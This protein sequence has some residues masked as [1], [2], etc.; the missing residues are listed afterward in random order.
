LVDWERQDFG[1][2]NAGFG[3]KRADSLQQTADSEEATGMTSLKDWQKEKCVQGG[4][5]EIQGT[6][7]K[8]VWS[9]N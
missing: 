4:Q 2:R 3:K 7:E 9:R 1:I 5:K 8:R 6:V